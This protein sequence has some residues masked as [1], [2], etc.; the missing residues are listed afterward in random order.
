MNLNDSEVRMNIDPKE[1]LT[2]IPIY[3]SINLT[4][5]S[6]I[7][8]V[9]VRECARAQGFPDDFRFLGKIFAQYKQVGNAVPPPLARA[10]GKEVKKAMITAEE[11]KPFTVVIKTGAETPAPMNVD[12]N[13]A[14]N[15]KEENSEKKTKTK[16]KKSKSKKENIFGTSNGDDAHNSDENSDKENHSSNKNKKASS[17]QDEKKGTKRKRDSVEEVSDDDVQLTRVTKKAKVSAGG[18]KKEK[19]KHK[20]KKANKES[21]FAT[22][23]NDM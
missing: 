3:F 17:S 10:I 1:I 21:I 14:A 6:S 18:D 4:Y 15:G 23:N 20:K 22:G 11:K 2:I 19:K 16:E 5:Q 13:H 9:S 7:R 8:V 12:Q